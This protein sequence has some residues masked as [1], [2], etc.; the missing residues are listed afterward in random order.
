MTLNS[1]DSDPLTRAFCSLEG[2]SVGDAFGERFFGFQH[3]ASIFIDDAD[4][5][6]AIEARVLPPPPWHYTDDTDMALSIVS[7]L[8][9]CEGID[10][11]DLAQS[12]ALRYDPRRGYGDAMH[13]L[14]PQFSGGGDWR[15]LAPAL[16]GGSGSF[17]NGAAMRVAPIGAYFADD[18][19]EAVEQAR[20]SA[21][22]THAHPEAVAGAIALAVA[23][24]YAC[25]FKGKTPPG[26]REFVE[27]L[28]RHIPKSVVRQRVS[29]ARDL[30]PG[31]SISLAV[32]A[33]GNGSEISAMDTVPF[34][35]WCAAQ[36]LD[37]YEEVLWLTVSG[38]GDRD[39]TCAMV[40]GVVACYT[41]IEGIPAAWRQ[42]R[43]PLPI[44]VMNYSGG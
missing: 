6:D 18:A 35:L 33:L 11:D 7:I 5:L 40:G 26:P 41:S 19:E 24:A 43:E 32:S 2:V 13:R 22:V 27:A 29:E 12:F 23:A 25:R 36:H 31:G 21:V 1:D 37:N 14:L 9:E 3:G 38:L 16:F 34:V 28:L 39:T 15:E 8:A 42:A 30:L 10:E 4:L 20:R 17:G 44:W